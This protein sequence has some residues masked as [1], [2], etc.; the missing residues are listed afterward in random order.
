MFRVVDIFSLTKGGVAH[1]LSK[2]KRE[3]TVPVDAGAA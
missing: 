1:L 2:L 3:S